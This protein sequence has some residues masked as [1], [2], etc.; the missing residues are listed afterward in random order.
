MESH[1]GYEADNEEKRGKLESDAKNLGARI[2]AKAG[3]YRLPKPNA[4]W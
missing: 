2:A 4:E 1:F 3:E